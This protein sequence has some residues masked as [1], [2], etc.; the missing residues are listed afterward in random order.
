MMIWRDAAKRYETTRKA[1]PNGTI[2]GGFGSR[3]VETHH[4][5]KGNFAKAPGGLILTD[6]GAAHFGGRETGHTKDQV[7]GSKEVR[8]WQLALRGGIGVAGTESANWKFRRIS[9]KLA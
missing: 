6:A 5:K 1:V 2:A 9:D 7:V 3:S 4:T 8:A